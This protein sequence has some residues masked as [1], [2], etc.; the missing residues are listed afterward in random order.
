MT[1]GTGNGTGSWLVHWIQ[2]SRAVE[3]K[4]SPRMSWSQCCGSVN[5]SQQYGCAG[6]IPFLTQ[7]VQTCRLYPFPPQQYGRAGVSLSTGITAVWTCRVYPSPLPALQCERA[8][9]YPSQSLAFQFRNF[10]PRCWRPAMTNFR[11]LIKLNYLFF[12]LRSVEV[13]CCS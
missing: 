13:S 8:W 11:L 3:N 7:E 12:C 2:K 9:C 4:S 5:I 10:F 6:G 1:Y